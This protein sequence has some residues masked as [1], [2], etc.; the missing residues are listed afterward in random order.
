MVFKSNKIK[1]LGRTSNTESTF[2]TFL[3]YL[4][5]LYPIVILCISELWSEFAFPSKCL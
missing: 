2:I 5:T 3:I 1:K 4:K